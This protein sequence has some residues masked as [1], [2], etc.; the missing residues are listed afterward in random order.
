MM[1]APQSLITDLAMAMAS[2]AVEVVDLTHTLD[3]A[4]AGIRPVR[5][6]PHGGG[7]GL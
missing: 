4:A 2:G 3:Q 7:V 1:T 5:P 6:L